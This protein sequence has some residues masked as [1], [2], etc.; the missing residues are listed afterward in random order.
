MS[1][2]RA[3]PGSGPAESSVFSEAHRRVLM[4]LYV[5]ARPLCQVDICGGGILDFEGTRVWVVLKELSARGVVLCRENLWSL[6]PATRE[7]MELG[8]CVEC[9]AEARHG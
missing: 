2:N 9:A 5:H 1:K 7:L 4:F 8:G 6:T 3:S